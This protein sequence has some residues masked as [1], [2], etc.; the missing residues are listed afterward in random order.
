MHNYKDKENPVP[1]SLLN[2]FIFCPAS[3]YFHM[4]DS[5]SVVISYGSSEQL[6]G[7]FVHNSIDNSH[8]S[9]KPNI[10]QGVP[11][12]CSKYNLIGKIDIFDVDRGLLIER[13]R[14]VTSLYDGFCFQLY[15]YCFALRESDFEVNE[16]QIYSYVDNKKYKVLLPEYD[17]IMFRK[18]EQ[19]IDEIHKF[20]LNLFKQTN[21]KKCDKCVYEPLCPFSCLEET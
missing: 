14:H 7:S 17:Q 3:I 5:D 12:F 2:D 18:F 15:S 19:T 6:Q 9:N 1:V 20:D 10:F 11:V 8:Y 4:V 16:L 13:K 21:K